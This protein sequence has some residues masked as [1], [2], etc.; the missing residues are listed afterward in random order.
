MMKKLYF[1]LFVLMNTAQWTKAQTSLDQLFESVIENNMAIKSFNAFNQFQQIEAKTGNA[2][3]NPE[4]E[5]GYYPG[6]SDVNGIKKVFSI[7]QTFDFPTTYIYKKKLRVN[8]QQLANQE[9]RETAGKVLE[10]AWKCWATAIYN[11]KKMGI[12]NEREYLAQQ[13]L[14]FYK[15]KQQNG[16]ATQ[17]EVNKA[18]LFWLEV[19]NQ[20]RLQ[21]AAIAQNQ[22]QLKYLTNN[23]ITTIADT[24]YY[25]VQLESWSQFEQKIDS[26]HPSILKAIIESDLARNET[27][28]AKS[29]QLPDFMIG[30][31]SEEVLGD[32][33]SGLKGGI[34]VPLWQQKG[35]I[36]TAKAKESYLQNNLDNLKLSIRLLYQN[37]YINTLALQ[38]N[39]VD[40]NKNLNL[41]NNEHLLARSLELGQIS[42]I[43]YFLE[44][45]YFYEITDQLLNL[46]LE[47]QLNL[48][49]LYAFLLI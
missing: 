44:L 23:Q 42:V 22:D 46:E 24:E 43:Q 6:N 18:Q 14:L 9:Y 45:H 7:S 32:R 35:T 34:T 21:Q 36:G 47:Y 40:Y 25:A 28:L 37:K 10:D 49:S 5:Y 27:F 11:N 15:K 12:I 1:L 41:M 2:P 48:A 20:K 4:I 26:I 3:K 8:Q 39:M 33:Y 31:E 29:K 16:D 38:N 30:Y 19:S 17:L 13:L